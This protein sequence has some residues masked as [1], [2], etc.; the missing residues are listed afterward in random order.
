MNTD[1]YGSSLFLDLHPQPQDVCLSYFLLLTRVKVSLPPRDCHLTL[2]PTVP[3]HLLIDTMIF[4]QCFFPPSMP[5]RSACDQCGFS[6]DSAALQTSKMA[7]RQLAK[8]KCMAQCRARPQPKMNKWECVYWNVHTSLD[9]YYPVAVDWVLSLGYLFLQDL[10]SE[11][12]Y[13]KKQYVCD[14]CGLNHSYA[15]ISKHGVISKRG[16][17]WGWQ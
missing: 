2:P 10:K 6:W 5:E 15:F 1:K 13:I 4:K 17:E 8:K 11:A 7:H 9:T 14:R 3:S 16:R 12:A